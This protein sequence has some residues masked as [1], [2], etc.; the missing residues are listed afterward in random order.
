MFGITVESKWKLPSLNLT[1]TISIIFTWLEPFG[2][3]GDPKHDLPGA[4]ARFVANL[5]RIHQAGVTITLTM[6]SWCTSF[7][8]E[9]WTE[10]K[11][12]QFTEYFQEI[13]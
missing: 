1:A 10:D 11:F 12:E 9:E 7:P 5:T 3:D 13:R 4:T 8:L 2:F 6:G